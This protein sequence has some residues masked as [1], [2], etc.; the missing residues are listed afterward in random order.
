VTSSGRRCGR[1]SAHPRSQLVTR[2]PNSSPA[3][4]TRLHDLDSAEKWLTQKGI[5]TSRPSSGVLAADPAGTFNAPYFFTTD[6]VPN[7][8]FE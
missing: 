5:G 6:P 7:D 4:R 8:P 1:I 2:D 3:V